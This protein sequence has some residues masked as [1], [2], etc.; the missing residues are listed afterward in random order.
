LRY[1]PSPERTLY[2]RY[3][4]LNPKSQESFVAAL[5]GALLVERMRRETKTS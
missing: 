4:T 1:D 2:L 5:I 3:V